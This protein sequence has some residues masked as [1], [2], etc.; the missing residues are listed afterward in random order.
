M[1]EDGDEER[2]VAFECM[3]SHSDDKVCLGVWDLESYKVKAFL[4]LDGSRCSIRKSLVL[5]ALLQGQ[6]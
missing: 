5:F 1:S 2:K 3:K 4:D 6:E